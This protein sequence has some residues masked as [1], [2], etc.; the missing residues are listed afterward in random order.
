MRRWLFGC[1]LFCFALTGYRTFAQLHEIDPAKLPQDAAATYAK[2]L[3][4]ERYAQAWSDKWTYDVPKQD[5][6]SSLNSA[7]TQLTAASKAAPDNHELQLLAG[8]VA[9]YAYNVDVEDAYDPAVHFLQSASASDTSDYRPNWFLGIHLCQANR[10]DLGMPRL[11]A[12]EESKDWN[13]L[14]VDFWNDYIACSLVTL[15]PAHGLRATDRTLQL[16]ASP[17]SMKN[18][19]ALEN[20]RYKPSDLASTYPA[21][22]AWTTDK[23]GDDVNFT[24]RLCGVSL[25]VHGNWEA[26]IGD[27]ANGTCTAT[28]GLPQYPAKHGTSSPSVLLLARPPKLKESLADFAGS[29]LKGRYAGATPTSATYCP[30]PSCL[31]FEILAKDMYQSEGGG[32]LLAVAFERDAPPYDGL[33][34]E[35]PI[36]PPKQ[37]AGSGPVY[38]HPDEVFRRFSGKLYYLVILDSN[39]SIFTPASKDFDFFL[40]SIRVE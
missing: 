28:F 19:L 6:A 39:A 3:P 8:L 20:K 29:F 38:F 15:M 35:R 1:L 9:H 27:V 23:Q 34:F 22:D 26:R 14:P 13:Q 31:S 30:N 11:L 12:V 36:T 4:M 16:G 7:L 32:H 10:G 25:A 40:H 5:V 33:I 37:T 2:A 18:I 21:R 17:V 24:T